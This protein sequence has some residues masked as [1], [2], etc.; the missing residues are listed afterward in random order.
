MG[1]VGF[2]AR[3]NWCQS[4][5]MGRLEQ[6]ESQGDRM[7]WAMGSMFETRLVT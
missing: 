1:K 3:D 6:K 7:Q 5:K 2:Q 4:L